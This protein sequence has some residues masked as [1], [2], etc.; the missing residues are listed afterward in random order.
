VIKQEPCTPNGSQGS[1]SQP[2]HVYVTGANY[3]MVPAGKCL[4]PLCCCS[5]KHGHNY[6]QGPH[7]TWDC[8]F[9]YMAPWGSC[10]GFLS[11]GQRSP[12]HW[13]CYTLNRSCKDVWVELITKL[14]LPDCASAVRRQVSA[15]Q[16]RHMKRGA[17]GVRGGSGPSHP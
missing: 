12:D 10:Q 7:A 13:S 11:S 9:R 14:D 3:N 8:P 6:Q 2:Q 4:T 1:L 5:A 15:S 17:V 16:L